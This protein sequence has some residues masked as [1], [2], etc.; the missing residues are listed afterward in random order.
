[1]VAIVEWPFPPRAAEPPSLYPEA[2]LVCSV[3]VKFSAAVSLPTDGVCKFLFFDS[4]YKDNLNSLTASNAFQGNVQEFLLRAQ[5]HA[6][7]EFGMSLSLEF[8]NVHKQSKTPPFRNGLDYLWGQGIRH[9]G[10]LNL[11]ESYATHKY[12]RSGGAVKVLKEI[13]Q[14]LRKKDAGASTPQTALGLAPIDAVESRKIARLVAKAQLPSLLI[15]LGHIS[16]ADNDRPNCRILPPTVFSFPENAKE[17]GHTLAD[18][19]QHLK[20]FSTLKGHK[21]SLALALTL[22]GRLYKP[23]NPDSNTQKIGNFDVFKPCQQTTDDMLVVPA[24]VST[25]LELAALSG[26]GGRACDSKRFRVE[27]QYALAAYD[28]DYDAWPKACT[29]LSLQGQ[30]L[31][32]GLLKRLNNFIYHNFT[33]YLN[34]TACTSIRF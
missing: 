25:I 11:Y 28:I 29:S 14:H 7:T 5:R 22:Q 31:R 34:R 30:F 27:F 21:L 24:S 13:V 16:Y 1:M 32:L 23:S 4:L 18:A 17:Y 19:I 10:I 2:P 12:I 9:Y 6:K 8:A 26:G 20:A 15:S 3:S 33:S